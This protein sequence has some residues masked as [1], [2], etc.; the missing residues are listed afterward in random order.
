MLK[1]EIFLNKDMSPAELRKV[2]AHEAMHAALNISGISELL[3]NKTEEAICVLIE[4]F[5]E[6]LVKI[7]GE[8]WEQQ[9]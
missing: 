8:T 5:T 4:S 7:W 2:A 6:D 9:S 1:R 3:P